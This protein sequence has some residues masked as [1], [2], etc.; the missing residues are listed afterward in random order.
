MTE[1]QLMLAVKSGDLEKAG[2]LFELYHRRIY[3]F[4]FK[5]CLE[6]DQSEDMTQNVFVRLIK[7]R[8][9]YQPSHKFKSWIYQIARNIFYDTVKQNKKMQT[10]DLSEVVMMRVDENESESELLL[11]KSL[12][13]LSDEDRQLLVFS[14]Y[15]NMRYEEIAGIMDMT[16]SNIKVKVHRAIHKLRKHYFELEKR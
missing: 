13:L 5:L 4:F 15:E 3:H 6:A 8:S 11:K 7:Y 14:K 12:S 2:E 16:V 1:E 10:E 9:S